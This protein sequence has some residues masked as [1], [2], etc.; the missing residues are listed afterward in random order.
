VFWCFGGFR[1]EIEKLNFSLGKK[2]VFLNLKTIK[3]FKFILQKK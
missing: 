3:T 2:I 1:V